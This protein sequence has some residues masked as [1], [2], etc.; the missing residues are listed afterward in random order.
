[1]NL[2]FFSLLWTTV[3]FFFT[4]FANAQF[5][6]QNQAE[7][8]AI[9][10]LQAKYPQ[11]TFTKSDLE[12][13][14][15][16]SGIS[17]Q[18][19]QLFMFNIAGGGY[20]IISGDKSAVP[21]IAYSDKSTIPHSELNPN[22]DHWIQ[23]YINQID[24]YRSNGVTN[25]PEGKAQWSFLLENKGSNPFVNT[26]SIEPLLRSTWGQDGNYQ[27]MCPT[28]NEG[29]ALV[30][31]I[32]TAMAQ[33][34]YYYRYPAT[35]NGSNSYNDPDFGTIYANF[36]ASNYDYNLMANKATTPMFE[37]AELCYH[38]G[39]AVNMNYGVNGSGANTF[40]VDDALENYFRYDTDAQYKSKFGVSDNTW[41][42]WLRSDLDNLHPVIY[43]GS[44][45]NGG[46]AFIIDGY[47]GTD[48]FHIDWGWDGYANGYYYLDALNPAG[49]DFNNWQDA[50]FNIYPPSSSYP[51]G[52]NGNTTLE[53]THG[54]IE[55]GS[56]PTMDYSA[57]SSCSWLISPPAQCDYFKISF[58]EFNIA[59]DDQLVIYAGPDNTS[60]IAGTYSGSTLPADLTVYSSKV[61][62]EFT[63]N[64]FNN[65]KGFLLNYAGHVPT[66]C[67]GIVNLTAETDT[68]DDGSGINHYGNNSFCR[69]SI[70]PPNA[71]A[72]TLHFLDFDLEE[73]YDYVRIIDGIH[74]NTIAEYSGTS[75]PP[76]TTVNSSKMIVMFTSN[77]AYTGQGFKAFYTVTTGIDESPVGVSMR[78]YP[79]P[80]KDI[81]NVIP[82]SEIH[83]GTI[84]IYDFMGKLVW[85][86]NFSRNN[87]IK[88]PVAGFSPGIYQIG[89]LS[90]NGNIWQKFMI[91]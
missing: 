55:D 1:M 60:T 12:L 86:Q 20:V 45:S 38:C 27:L 53:H 6:N 29:T 90:E 40:N 26:K 73:T 33:V 82:G 47:D 23:N 17:S 79:N 63:S 14:N 21:V 64:N 15:S 32:A 34:I 31:C 80:V 62:I 89:L 10:F 72:I 39:V 11:K 37:I 57:N 84:V 69:W 49:N 71:S 3:L 51:L 50:V 67:L 36:G 28:N 2:H 19:P 9:S 41:K 65:G 44:G 30:G 52:C 76:A 75:L 81:L 68:F 13:N 4:F 77:A 91:E 70:S 59:S 7:D 56:G 61:F 22:F 85:K 87:S 78:M 5:V 54:S 35:G 24:F 42:T 83:S 66:S 58:Q 88:I 48:Y 46:H 43:S 74:G 18:N 8:A 16:H 25:T